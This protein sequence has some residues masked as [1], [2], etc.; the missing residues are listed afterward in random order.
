MAWK[1]T[2]KESVLD[3]L[4][5]FGR[6][7]GRQLLAEAEAYLSEGPLAETRNL[8]TLRPNP[9]AQRELRLAGKYRILF[10]ID[11][12]E[13]TVTILL[14]GEKQ[15]NKLIVQGKEFTAHHEDPPAE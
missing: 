10:N 2:L 5:W 12:S 3:D 8:K 9:F 14:V 1:V 15:G 7:V 4:R 13:E 6:K 11:K